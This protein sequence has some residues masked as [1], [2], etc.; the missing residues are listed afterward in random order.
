MDIKELKKELNQMG[1]NEYHLQSKIV[2]LLTFMAER[3]DVIANAMVELDTVVGETVDDLKFK[4]G[5]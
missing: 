2:K 5:E 3:L 1:D 4:V